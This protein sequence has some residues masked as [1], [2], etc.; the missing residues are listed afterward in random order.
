M[1]AGFIWTITKGLCLSL[2]PHPQFIDKQARKAYSRAIWS[3]YTLTILTD[4][5]GL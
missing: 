4:E 5:C 2:S 1:Q 3:V